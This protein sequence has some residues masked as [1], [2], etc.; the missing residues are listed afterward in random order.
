LAPDEIK[1]LGIAKP[2][3]AKPTPGREP[4]ELG[5]DNRCD[6][7]YQFLVYTTRSNYDYQRDNLRNARHDAPVDLPGAFYDVLGNLW[8]A[9]KGYYVTVPNNTADA[10]KEK[11]ARMA[12]AKL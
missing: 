2:P 1:N 10:V 11:M 6:F 3:P 12:A 5:F 4:D 8:F 9:E 7:G